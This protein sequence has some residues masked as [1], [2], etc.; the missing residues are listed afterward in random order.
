[1]LFGQ[2]FISGVV[3][4]VANSMDAFVSCVGSEVSQHLVLPGVGN[5]SFISTGDR[6]RVDRTPLGVLLVQRQNDIQKVVQCAFQTNVKIVP[7]GGGHSYESL[8]SQD[9]SIT[10]DLAAVNQV[11]IVSREADGMTAIAKVQAGARLGHVYNQL[12]KQGGYTFNG[13]TC[14]SVGI[15]GHISGGGYGMLARAYG[16]AADQTVGFKMILFNGT[17]IEVNAN[18]HPDLFWAQRSGGSGSFGIVTEWLIKVRNVGSVVM[19]NLVYEK[20][21]R[22]D[23]VK[24]WM[25]YFPTADS[26]LTT[27]LNINKEDALLHGQFTGPQADLERILQES[28][29]Y[30]FGGIKHQQQ[31]TCNALGAKAFT[32][33][34]GSCD[35]NW[36]YLVPEIYNRNKDSGKFK[37]EY[38]SVRLSDDG[39][40]A[41]VNGISEAPAWGWLQFEAL[42][43]FFANVSNDAL[44]YN[45]RDSLFSMQYATSLGKGESFDSPGNQWIKRFEA[46]LK[47]FV[48]GQHYQNYPDLE[49]GADFG[50]AYFGE[51]NFA[52]LRSIKGIYDP[53]NYFQNE[54]SIPLPQ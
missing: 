10:V 53:Q 42:G 7:R 34:A 38:G 47:P 3:A 13:G 20:D 40:R 9:G 26:R 28:G 45:H 51:K 11:S 52:R 15:S 35:E 1:M 19:F 21:K 27:Q 16:L 22:F 36:Q 43:G 50:R 39:I 37:S 12:W 2:L 18:S 17:E 32:A 25:N 30:N 5:Y 48:N 54:Q 31:E 33:G 14:P 29:V 24:A 44:P 46:S 6:N 23:L 4:A 49:L 41:V 8:S